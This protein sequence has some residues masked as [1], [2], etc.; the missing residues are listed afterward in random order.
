MKKVLIFGGIA[1][2]LGA[3]AYFGYKAYKAKQTPSGAASPA[4]A[5][6]IV[7]SN[8]KP[9][10]LNPPPSTPQI[11]QQTVTSRA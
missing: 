10:V 4:L 11:T 6:P 7:T 8:G 2:V 9:V 5:P 1:I 3:I